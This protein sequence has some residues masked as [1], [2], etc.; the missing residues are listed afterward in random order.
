MI[1]NSLKGGGA[2]D[3]RKKTVSIIVLIICILALCAAMWFIGKP[4]VAYASSPR[5]FTQWVSMHALS[6]RLVY[7]FSVII[8]II[9]AFIPGEPFEILAGYAFGAFEGTV[10]CLIAETLG[11]LA[12]FALVRRFGMRLV[13]LFFSEEKI[14]NIRFLKATPKRDF[15]FLLIFAL[16]GTPKDL[17]C[18]FA[19]LTD[20]R[21][22]VWFIICSLGRVP[23]II[24]STLGGSA[25][26]EK[27]YIF[28]AV[29]FA[30]TL[31]ISGLGLLLYNYICKKRSKKQ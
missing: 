17:L 13:R 1:Y 21:F 14:K 20:I 22:P 6:G 8:Q 11:S 28:A 24:T 29:V 27:N 26:L 4:L 23:A 16:P 9:F 25:L 30:L 2:M 19:G 12:V 31:A 10:L 5:E 7:V 18:Y 15:I 3:K